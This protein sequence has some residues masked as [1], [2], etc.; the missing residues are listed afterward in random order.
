MSPPLA[1]GRFPAPWVLQRG[2]WWQPELPRV[3]LIVKGA[4]NGALPMPHV[5]CLLCQCLLCQCSWRA[6]QLLPRLFPIQDPS[7][8]AAEE[9]SVSAGTEGPAGLW[10]PGMSSL[11]YPHCCFCLEMPI[12]DP[13]QLHGERQ[14]HP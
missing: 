6:E 4:G 10:E 14:E 9:S 7:V 13:A 3:G 5:P 8:P 2:L 12:P 11:L 1:A